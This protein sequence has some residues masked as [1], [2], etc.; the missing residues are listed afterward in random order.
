VSG[1]SLERAVAASGDSDFWGLQRFSSCRL[2]AVGSR[3]DV[4]HP[5]SEVMRQPSRLNPGDP[6]V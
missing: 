3:T 2:R 5:D 4:Q 1:P 6:E